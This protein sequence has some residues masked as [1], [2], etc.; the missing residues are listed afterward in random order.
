M[1]FQFYI[2]DE[3]FISTFF[4]EESDDFVTASLHKIKSRQKSVTFQVCFDVT[5]HASQYLRL[6]IGTLSEK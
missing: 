4:L 5:T 3:S 6:H 2:G 1:H